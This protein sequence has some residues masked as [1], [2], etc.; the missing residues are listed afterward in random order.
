[1]NSKSTTLVTFCIDS[2]LIILDTPSGLIALY[3]FNKQNNQPDFDLSRGW[4][5][6][7]DDEGG[8]I[9]WTKAKFEWATQNPFHF[10]YSNISPNNFL[11]NLSRSDQQRAWGQ[12]LRSFVQ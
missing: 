2:H 5:W 3:D 7:R 10:T 8:E 1:M 4:V 6:S 9:V 12:P 11:I